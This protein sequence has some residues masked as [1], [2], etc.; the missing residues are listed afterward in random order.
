MSI[1]TEINSTNNRVS[2][3]C[4]RVLGTF[5]VIFSYVKVFDKL[6]IDSY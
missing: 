3:T 6:I 5:D 1:C 4:Q 2:A